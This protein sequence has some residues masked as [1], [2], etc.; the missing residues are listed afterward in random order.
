MRKNR[1]GFTITELIIV[2]VI[3]GILT[4]I[5]IVSYSKIQA[6]TRDSQ[7]QAKATVL[8]EA[9]EKYYDK[10]G[11]YP[12]CSAMTAPATTV[13]TSTLKGID[14]SALIVPTAGSGTSTSVQSG[15]TNPNFPTGTDEILY[16]G[17][18]SSTCTTTDCLQYTIKYLKE[19]DGTVATIAS[20][21]KTNIATNG[22]IT[23][24]GAFAVSFTQL[25][26]NWTAVTNAS[27]YTVQRATDSG[28]A[29]NLVSTDFTSN[30]ATV[31]G[32]SANTTYFFRVKPNFASGS[33]IWSNTVTATTLSLNAPT[34]SA[35]A[36]SSTQITVSWSAVTNAQTYD[37]DQS[38]S[39]SF[40]SP[41]TVTGVTT[42]NKAFTGLTIGTTYYYRARA[43]ASGQNSNNSN[44]ASAIALVLTVPVTTATTNSN[45]Q[46]TASWPAITNAQSYNIDRS[47]SASFTSPTSVT[48]VTTTSY[49]TTGL[50]PGTTYYFRV[51]AY[52]Y[53]VTTAW[54][55]TASATTTISAP[56][57]TPSAAVSISGGTATGT[58]SAVACTYGTPYYQ[59]AYN[60][61]DGGINYPAYSASNTVSFG[62]NED[63]KAGV[64]TYAVCKGTSISSAA[65]GGNYASA[66]RGIDTPGAP[67]TAAYVSGSTAVGYVSSG[68]G[69]AAGTPQYEVAYNVND[70]GITYP[71]WTG[72]SVSFGVNEDTKVG[73]WTYAYCQGTYSASASS[74]GNYAS[75]IR[76]ID[77]PGAPGVASYISGG[78]AVGYISSGVGCAA[79][80]PRYQT[81]YNVNDGGSTWPG[82]DNSTIYEGAN[83]GYKYGY[84][85]YA[86]CQGTYSASAANGGNYSSSVRGIDVPAAPGYAGPYPAM[87][88]YPSTYNINFTPYCPGGTW[89][90]NGTFRSQSWSGGQYGPHPWGYLDNWSG[91]GSRYVY[92]WGKY[93]C[94]TSYYTSGVSGESYTAV[95]VY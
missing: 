63:N 37:I 18:N 95:L 79:G 32:M 60:L 54:S 73:Y 76:G 4:A 85:G 30:P 13:S 71:G 8:A 74:G 62:I 9:L 52:A 38:T 78:T 21:R 12:S 25:N 89:A 80:Y 42:T 1:S 59:V 39:A 6:S 45:T 16:V 67:G 46:I 3:I 91:G 27:G 50:A 17:D 70:G 94:G 23:D 20:R 31:T 57:S 22:N 43:V 56:T 53:G 51:A 64:W 33:G 86:Y 92:Y 14:P 87:Y 75:T 41:T 48:G 26:L 77:T 72:S 15:C 55:A 2:V 28:F 36:N 66:I 84:W 19:S 29:N 61:N 68:V 24:L 47:T 40:T 90:V 83:Q 11:E 88:S 81:P 7:R 93:Q 65:V 82:W 35:T 44:T 49:V 10:N 34:I 58:A 5:S 69:C